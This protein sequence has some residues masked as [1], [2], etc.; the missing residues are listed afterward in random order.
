LE[1][2]EARV[3]RRLNGRV[4]DF[5]LSVEHGGL[6]LQGCTHSYYVKQLAQQAVME[7]ALL[8]IQANE[9]EVV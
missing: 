6:V 3:Q 5:R 4:R 7:V 1:Q 8:P 9:I 2:I